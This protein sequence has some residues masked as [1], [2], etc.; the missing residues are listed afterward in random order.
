M[1]TTTIKTTDELL[2][3]RD[4]K[5]VIRI[6]GI[7]RIECDVPHSIGSSIFG[8]IVSGC[9]CCAGNMELFG[10]LSCG[11]DMDFLGDVYIGGKLSCGGAIR[12]RGF[13]SCARGITTGEEK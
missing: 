4:Y 8:I 7:L 1:A 5:K 2:A 6:D 13:I 10:D 3:L 11:D 12:C 9:V